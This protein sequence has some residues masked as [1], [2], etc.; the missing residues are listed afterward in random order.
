I[1]SWRIAARQTMN[2]S[3]EE[4]LLR[5]LNGAVHLI[6]AR[7][8]V[9]ATFKVHVGLPTSA[10]YS[11]RCRRNYHSRNHTGMTTRPLSHWNTVLSSTP[12]LLANRFRDQ[13][14]PP[15]GHDQPLADGDGGVQG[16]YPRNSMSRGTRYGLGW[17][18]AP[19]PCKASGSRGGNA[20]RM[21]PSGYLGSF[22]IVIAAQK[23]PAAGLIPRCA[24]WTDRGFASASPAHPLSPSA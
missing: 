8:H 7:P 20:R 19:G 4:R 9:S 23:P 2:R 6:G 24:D 18:P 11:E 13:P 3:A 22:P 1:R 17:L 15:P 12:S 16:T 14:L 10:G 5:Q 21:E